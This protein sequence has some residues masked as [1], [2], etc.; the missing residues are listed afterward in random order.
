MKVVWSVIALA[1]AAGVPGG[2]SAKAGGEKV[3]WEKPETALATAGATGKPVC[4]YFLTNEIVKGEGG[5]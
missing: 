3:A 2:A 5:G 4:F 1:L